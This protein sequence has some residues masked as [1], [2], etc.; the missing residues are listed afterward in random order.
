MIKSINQ[1]D[2]INL[3][4]TEI[5]CEIKHMHLL[6]VNHEKA[7]YKLYLLCSYLVVKCQSVILEKI[8]AYTL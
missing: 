3:L 4:N 5:K 6:C 7:P 8:V 1:N 2:Q